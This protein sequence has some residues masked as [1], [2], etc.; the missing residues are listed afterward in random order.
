METGICILALLII[1]IA[2]QL[3]DMQIRDMQKDLDE[4]INDLEDILNQ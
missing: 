4:H 3:L 1:N 2:L